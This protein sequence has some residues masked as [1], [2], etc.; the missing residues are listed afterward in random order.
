MADNKIKTQSIVIQ[1]MNNYLENIQ[2]TKTRTTMEY[3][4]IKIQDS[5]EEN[6]ETL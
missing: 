2:F 5:R 3:L 4:G 1:Y 6:L